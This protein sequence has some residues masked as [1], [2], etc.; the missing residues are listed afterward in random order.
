MY[1]KIYLLKY[2]FGAF[3]YY[4]LTYFFGQ[5]L[6]IFNLNIFVL[7]VIYILYIFA[8]WVMM[9]NKGEFCLG[10]QNIGTED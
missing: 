6:H 9:R 8:V 10:K 5:Y 1:L 7:S 4:F 2:I 3:L